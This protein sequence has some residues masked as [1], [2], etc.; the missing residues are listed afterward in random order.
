MLN[1]SVLFRRHCLTLTR[2]RLVGSIGGTARIGIYRQNGQYRQHGVVLLL[3]ERMATGIKKAEIAKRCLQSPVKFIWRLDALE[4][5][6]ARGAGERDDVAYVGHSGDKQY[7]A[8]EAEAEA[9]VGYGAEATGIE[10]PPHVFHGDAKFLDAG[11]QF[12]VAFFS[13]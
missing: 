11:K 10:V 12:L 5:G 7:E 1:N 9:R 8:L 13:F 3:G 6:V 2:Y 4:L